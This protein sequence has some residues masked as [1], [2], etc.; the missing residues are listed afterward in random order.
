MTITPM[1]TFST[2]KNIGLFP[3]KHFY[4]EN[5]VKKYSFMEWSLFGFCLAADL[6]LAGL[7]QKI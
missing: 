4:S 7:S 3:F 1:T 6:S 5:T 2:A